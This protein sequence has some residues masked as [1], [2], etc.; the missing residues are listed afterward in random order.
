MLA[1]GGAAGQNVSAVGYART[2]ALAERRPRAGAQKTQ[3]STCRTDAVVGSQEVGLMGLR[4]VEQATN[5]YAWGQTQAQLQPVVTH[6]LAR[7]N[8][9]QTGLGRSRYSCR[10]HDT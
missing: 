1:G 7:R 4:Q 3:D 6:M 9:D 2:Q 5:E 8:L 10:P